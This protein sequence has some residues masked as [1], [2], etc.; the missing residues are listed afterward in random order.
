MNVIHSS[1]LYTQSVVCI[2]HSRLVIRWHVAYL[3]AASLLRIPPPYERDPGI[4]IELRSSE[5]IRTPGI[6]YD[7]EGSLEGK[8]KA[9]KATSFFLGVLHLPQTKI[10][11]TW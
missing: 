8:K 4:D 2:T 10:T 11:N 1:V 9:A 3:Q 6:P 5:S 7:K